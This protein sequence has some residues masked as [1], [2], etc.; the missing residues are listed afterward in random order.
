M[1]LMVKLMPGRP[2]DHGNGS[3]TSVSQLSSKLLGQTAADQQVCRGAGKQ[4]GK[5]HPMAAG[6]WIVI[7]WRLLM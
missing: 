1:V 2:Q 5:Q 7:Q 4:Q 6:C 3:G